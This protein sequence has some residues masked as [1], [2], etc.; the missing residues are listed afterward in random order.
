MQEKYKFRVQVGSRV[1][2]TGL[3]KS[4][5]TKTH[6]CTLLD[7]QTQSHPHMAAAGQC[8]TLRFMFQCVWQLMWLCPMC[9][10]T[11]SSCPDTLRDFHCHGG[12]SCCENKRWLHPHCWLSLN[13]VCVRAFIWSVCVCSKMLTHFFSPLFTLLVPSHFFLAGFDIL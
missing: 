7:I 12:A 10:R 3:E 9:G 5:C 2:E 1:I 4:S 6:H 11:P 8:N 13:Y